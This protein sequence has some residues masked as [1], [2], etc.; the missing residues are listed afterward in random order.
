MISDLVFADSI[1]AKQ[2]IFRIMKTDAIQFSSHEFQNTD[3]Q[4]TDTKQYPE[5]PMHLGFYFLMDIHQLFVDSFKAFVNLLEALVH[6]L[7]HQF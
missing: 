4:T 6:F 2:F 1:F 7:T 3:D 5:A